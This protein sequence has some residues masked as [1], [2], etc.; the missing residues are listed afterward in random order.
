MK[1]ITLELPNELAK[2]F[3]ALPKKRKANA[4]LLAAALAK[5]DSRPIADIFSGID[6][7]IK[8][9]GVNQEEINRLLD[10]LS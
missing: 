8:K 3:D 1:T 5:A 10:E 6:D 9:S 2:V 4:A 7:R